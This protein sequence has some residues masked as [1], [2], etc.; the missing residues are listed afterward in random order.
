MFCL[1][2]DKGGI[3][4]LKPKPGYKGKIGTS[5]QKFVFCLCEWFGGQGVDPTGCNIVGAGVTWPEVPV[6]IVDVAVVVLAVELLVPDS[7]LE[8]L[9]FGF[10]W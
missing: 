2:D 9:G 7:V 8:V 5:G 3:H 1:L 10:E 6:G 4:I